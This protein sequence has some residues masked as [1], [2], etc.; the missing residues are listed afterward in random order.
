MTPKQSTDY[1]AAISALQA[2]FVVLPLC[3]VSNLRMVSDILNSLWQHC[4]RDAR[5]ISRGVQVHYFCVSTS[6][7]RQNLFNKFFDAWNIIQ[8]LMSIRSPSWGK[9]KMQCADVT[10]NLQHTQKQWWSPYQLTF[11]HTSDDRNQPLIDSY[12]L[13]TKK[14]EM[15]PAIYIDDN[16]EPFISFH[17]LT[18]MMTDVRPASALSSGHINEAR[19][20]PLISSQ[21][22]TKMQKMR[23]LS[24]LICSHQWSLKWGLYLLTPKMQ[25]MKPSSALTCSH[26]WSTKWDPYGLSDPLMPAKPEYDHWGSWNN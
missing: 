2:I 10:C 14:P 4:I 18:P 19:T 9:A 26:Q 24:A 8:L 23:P 3:Y 20:E 11:A 6:W 13:T 17:L 22:L 21:L 1:H 16:N 15:R 5:H 25:K 7:S 12:F